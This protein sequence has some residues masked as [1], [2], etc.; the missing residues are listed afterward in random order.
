MKPVPLHIVRYFKGEDTRLLSKHL[1]KDAAFSVGNRFINSLKD[2][3]NE[4]A[5]VP[6][7]IAITHAEN[8]DGTPE[9]LLTL[10]SRSTGPLQEGVSITLEAERDPSWDYPQYSM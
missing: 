4:S 6:V 7:I 8:D 10:T 3:I 5:E 9:T 1:Y 2:K